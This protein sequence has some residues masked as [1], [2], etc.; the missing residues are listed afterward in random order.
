MTEKTS[1]EAASAA[2]MVLRDPNASEDAKS[3][4]GSALTQREKER[5][6]FRA[7]VESLSGDE[8]ERAELLPC[9]FCGSRNV[10]QRFTRE[11]SFEAMSFVECYDCGARGSGVSGHGGEAIEEWNRRAALQS[12]DREDAEQWA[13]VDG[14]V[15]IYQISS[16]GRV[17]SLD[18]IDSDGNARKGKILNPSATQK[19]YLKVSLWAAGRREERYVH[20]MVAEAFIDNRASLPQ[21]N[22]LDGDPGNNCRS[23]LEWVTNSENLT[24]ARR[25][26]KKGV[27]AV[28]GI[29]QEDG[30]RVNFP[31]LQHAVEAGFTRANI[32]KSIAGIRSHHKGYQWF[33]EAIDHARRVEGEL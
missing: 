10:A 29:H 11:A 32:Q 30:S 27:R 25:V 20:R 15:G 2:A 28:Y 7:L 21:V 22:H 16:Y 8:Q 1:K 6:E 24:H 31:S 17:R 3:A 19:G 18:R 13:D 14:Y 23:N 9:L 33:D 12:Q 26:L 5:D 4:A